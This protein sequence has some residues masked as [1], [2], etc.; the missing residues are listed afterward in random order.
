MHD[1]FDVL[2]SAENKKSFRANFYA[3]AIAELISCFHQKAEPIFLVG[4]KVS[5]KGEPRIKG[6]GFFAHFFLSI[7]ILYIWVFSASIRSLNCGLM[8]S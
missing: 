3:K 7:S 1:F 4:E 2:G 5:Y 8:S 6:D